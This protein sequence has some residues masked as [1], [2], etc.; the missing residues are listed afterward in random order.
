MRELAV[1]RF[2][3]QG[4]YLVDEAGAEVLLPRGEVPPGL[5]HGDKL[6][7]FLYLDS[8]DR[9]VA[10]LRTPFVQLDGMASLL[11]RDVNDKGAFL[12]WGLTKDLFVPFR[13][14]NPRMQVGEFHVVRLCLDRL[15]GRLFATN[16]ISRF[17][18]Q[19]PSGYAPG[20]EVELLVIER[21]DLGWR[22]AVDGVWEG[23]LF[24]ED[25]RSVHIAR[26]ER[27]RGWVKRLR[28]DGK[29]DL[30]VHPVGKAAL[31]SD[32]DRLLQRLEEA[33]DGWLPVHDKSDPD[34]IEYAT[35][36]SKKAFKR[37]LGMLYRERLVEIG[38]NGIRLV[39]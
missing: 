8:E 2:T 6:R 22:V 34:E 12:D 28:D 9:P 35:G 23:L 32:R 15:T 3:L 24:D 1:N 30:S 18:K 4:I 29:L 11:V 33:P 10:T 27:L 16:R 36:L 38:E 5:G 21:T 19:D 14:Q 39:G 20:T 25:A 13:E 7:V 31:A 17:L 26:G 37:A